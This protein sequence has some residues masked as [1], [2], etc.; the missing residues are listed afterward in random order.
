MFVPIMSGDRAVQVPR[1]ADVE[2]TVKVKLEDFAV[3]T[4]I[5]LDFL[6]RLQNDMPHPRK[7]GFPQLAPW[8][9]LKKSLII[10]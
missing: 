5:K 3:R 7:G 9:F 10:S 1:T 6:T 4:R 8:R 2:F